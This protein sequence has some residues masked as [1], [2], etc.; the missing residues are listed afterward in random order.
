MPEVIFNGPA[1][2]LE[3]RFHE[4]KT[5]NAPIAMVLHPHPRFG[6][7]I[8]SA[9]NTASSPRSATGRKPWPAL[10]WAITGPCTGGP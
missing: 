10:N 8:P 4:S 3:G 2:R 5:T 9:W 1:G 6:G 7:P